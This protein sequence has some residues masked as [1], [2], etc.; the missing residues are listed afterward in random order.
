MRSLLIGILILTCSGL[1]DAQENIRQVDFRNFTY[2]LGGPTLGHD[3]LRWLDVSAHRRVRL[4][5]GKGT[6]VMPGLTLKSVEFADVT[7]DG[8]EDAVTV[9]HFDTGGTQQTDYVYIYSFAAG[10]PKLLAYFHSGD[11]AASGL[12]KVYGENGQ[13]VRRVVRSRQKIR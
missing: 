13:L 10:K 7:S 3:R 11:R 8:L 1:A 6:A 12:H 2:P 5:D 4:A 9:I